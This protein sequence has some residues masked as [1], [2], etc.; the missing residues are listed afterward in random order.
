[1]SSAAGEVPTVATSLTASDR[2][3]AWRVRWGVGRMRFRVS[4]GLYAAGTPDDASPV[5]VTANY[6]LSFDALRR[7]L[8]GADAWML[9]LDTQGVNVWC[10]AGKGTFG[11]IEVIRRV[12]ETDLADV[13]SHRTLVLP[14]LG[15]PG[16]AAYD[17]HAAT[18]FRVVY[19]PV[20][21]ADVPAFLSAGM[22]ATAEMRRVTFTLRERLVLTP[23][24]LAI[25]WRPKTLLA[26]AV[27]VLLSGVGGWG[28]STDAMVRRGAFTALA[29]LAAVLAGGFVTPALLPWIP[30]RAFSLKGA[31]VG[32]LFS[33]AVIAVVGS[34]GIR[35]NMFGGAAIVL[36]VTAAASYLAMN[37]TG[38]TPVASPSGVTWEMRRALP[39]QVSAAALAVV[40]WVVSAFLGVT[41]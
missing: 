28:F 24:E 12:L 14:Q 21:A 32:L 35:P 7:E 19:G 22:K 40:A 3:G 34:A 26:L 4:P 17:V 36:G 20:R 39:F 27:V 1:M 38:A 8:G 29:A 2:L 18:G 11:T 30:G 33:I 25:A 31:L 5:L 23:V 41:P 13:V 10:A 9:V 6:K 16:V 15:A 37:F